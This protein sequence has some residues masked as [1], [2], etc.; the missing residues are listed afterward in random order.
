MRAM[1]GMSLGNRKKQQILLVEYW[2]LAHS[3][4]NITQGQKLCKYRHVIQMLGFEETM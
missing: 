3:W 1:C 4:A 2:K